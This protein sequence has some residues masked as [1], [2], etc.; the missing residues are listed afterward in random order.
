MAVTGLDSRYAFPASLSEKDRLGNQ[1]TM[2]KVMYGWTKPVPNIIDLSEVRNVLDIGAGTCVWTLDLANDPQI[3]SRRDEVMI[4]ACDINVSIFPPIT[5]TDNAGIKTF[6][7]DIVKPFP[8]EY[9]GKFDLV[10]VSYL[11]LCLTEEGWHAALANINTLLIPGG[12][13][14]IDELD[15][16]LFKDGQYSLPVDD[17]GYD[18]EKCM[19]GTSWIGKLNCLYT[20]FILRNN[21]VVGL[22]FRLGGILEQAG[23]AVE[24]TE[25]GL[26]PLG[27]LCRDFNGLGG[28][29]LAEFEDFSTFNI[30]FSVKH[31]VAIMLKNGT[32]EVPRGHRVTDEEDITAVLGEVIEGVKTE[33]AIVVGRYFVA[34][35]L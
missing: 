19:A 23:F 29:S 4:Y 5:V 7:Q 25:E 16:V 11:V 27:K 9:H 21:F 33:G 18:L 1:Y 10:H 8:T 3:R 31:F 35:K 30:E 24:A 6:Q 22:T 26:L 2:K 12:R 28:G 15:P 13:L 20:G 32:L 17:E 34:K 14:M